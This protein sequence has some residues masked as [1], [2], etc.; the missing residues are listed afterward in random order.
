[1]EKKLE[2][3]LGFRVLGFRNGSE[4]GCYYIIGDS[5]RATIGID[6]S[7]PYEQ[8]VRLGGFHACI[9]HFVNIKHD[10]P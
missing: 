6:S 3:N 1:M 2:A 8:P 9:L 10:L 5:K 7:L 4:N